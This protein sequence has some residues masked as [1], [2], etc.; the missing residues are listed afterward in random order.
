[1]SIGPEFDSGNRLDEL[2]EARCSKLDQR[3]FSFF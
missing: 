1:M 3:V 2:N